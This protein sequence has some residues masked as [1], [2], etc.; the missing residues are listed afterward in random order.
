MLVVMK[1]QASEEQV[2]AVCEKIEK[3]GY[4]AHPMPGATRTA[5]GIT[6]NNG[7][8]EHG[9]LEEMPGVQRSHTGF[10]TLQAGQP[11]CQGR[12]HRVSPLFRGRRGFRRYSARHR[13]GPLRDR[14]PRAE[15]LVSA[16]RVQGA[17][18]PVFRGGAY[19]PR[20]SPYSFKVS[21][22]RA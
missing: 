11:R 12:R 16:E 1:A 20:T 7:E 15:H 19:K 5:I 21:A 17:G 22:K 13:R 10:E 3:L 8:V 4:R 14:K 6:G 2:S 18:A 9:T